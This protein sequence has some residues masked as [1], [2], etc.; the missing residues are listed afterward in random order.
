MTL[1]ACAPVLLSRNVPMVT[2]MSVAM[3]ASA[4]MPMSCTTLSKTVLAESP[5]IVPMI[6]LPARPV[7]IL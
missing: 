7:R 4:E 6:E 5:W 1:L 3:N 2:R